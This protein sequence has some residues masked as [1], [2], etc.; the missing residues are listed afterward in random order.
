MV[1][2]RGH[3]CKIALPLLSA[4]SRSRSRIVLGAIFGLSDRSRV[5]PQRCPGLRISRLLESGLRPAS[6][7][8]ATP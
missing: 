1:D 2:P 3:R 8:F 4:T 5:S 6:L 7:N